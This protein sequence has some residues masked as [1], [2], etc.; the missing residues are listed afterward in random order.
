MELNVFQYYFVLE[1]Y[2]VVAVSGNSIRM[3]TVQL[4]GKNFTDFTC[5]RLFTQVVTYT[6]ERVGDLGRS[7]AVRLYTQMQMTDYLVELF[8]NDYRD[9]I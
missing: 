4:L 9:N 1:N 8:T 2:P 6:E 3:F 7:L 5:Q